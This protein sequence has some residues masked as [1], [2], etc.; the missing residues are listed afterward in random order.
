MFFA[1]LTNELIE[2]DWTIEDIEAV[3]AFRAEA[4]EVAHVHTEELLEELKDE[5]ATAIQEGRSFGSWKRGMHLK[6]FEHDAPHHLKTNFNTAANNAQSAAKWRNIQDA[7]EIFPYLRYVAVMDDRVRD[8]HAELH[9][10][11]AHVDDE[12]WNEFYPPNGWNCRCEVEQ[13]TNEQGAQ[14]ALEPKPWMPIEDEFQKNTGKD[15]NIW[16]KWLDRKSITPTN[17]QALQR[18]SVDSW[19]SVKTPRTYDSAGVPK[20]KMI[21]DL[22]NYLDDRVV[23]DFPVL[24]PKAS[25]AKLKYLSDAELRK[26]MKYMRTID[27]TIT[28]ADEIWMET[29][30]SAVYAFKKFDDGIIVRATIK[31]GKL[32]GFSVLDQNVDQL[33]KGIPISQ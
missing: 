26:R 28:S 2:Y 19:S 30:R 13:L 23:G 9:D 15:L 14:R 18:N 1:A 27:P 24:L 4:F 6:G 16:G 10:T 17:Y 22:E 29:D 25:A 21:S 3:H 20:E 8:E 33:R 5:A 31:N 7:K 12:F 11:V 32:D